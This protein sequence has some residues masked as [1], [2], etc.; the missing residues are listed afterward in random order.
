MAEDVADAAPGVEVMV[1]SSVTGEGIDALRDRLDGRLTMAL[2]G[3]S[4]HGKSSLTNALVGAEVLSPARSGRT[5]AVGTRRYGASWCRCP[6]G[7]RSS[8]RPA[9]GASA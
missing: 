2:L 1:V 8:T 5:A 9:C 7:A 4:G 3:A 6:A